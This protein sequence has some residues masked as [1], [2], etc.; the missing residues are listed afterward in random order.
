MDFEDNPHLLTFTDF[1]E[2][3]YVKELRDRFN[4]SFP[5]IRTA[6]ETARDLEQ[7]ANPFAHPNFRTAVVGKSIYLYQ[8]NKPD[9][10][11]GLTHERGQVSSKVILQD[12]IESLEFDD[13]DIAKLY[14]A[15]QVPGERIV[16]ARDYN[17]GIPM[18][19][20]SL[21]TAE[22]L[23]NAVASEGGVQEAALAYDVKES[24]VQVAMDYL[25]I[26]KRAA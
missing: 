1:V 22:T 16:A 25:K 8:V 18:M 2:A 10:M 5:V 4:I 17:L 7:I 3:L 21:Y 15:Y 23:W 9:L 19:E 26:L 6:I 12:F 11:T 24:T 14:V 13:E 20:S